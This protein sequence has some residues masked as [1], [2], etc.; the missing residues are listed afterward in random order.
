MSRAHSLRKGCGSSYFPPI[1][2]LAKW[3]MSATA[4]TS[5]WLTRFVRPR[6]AFAS[7]E[8]AFTRTPRVS[9]IPFPSPSNCRAPSNVVGTFFGTRFSVGF[10]LVGGRVALV[11]DPLPPGFTGEAFPGFIGDLTSDFEGEGGEGSGSGC[12][13]RDFLFCSCSSLSASSISAR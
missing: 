6:I 10:S 13:W 7:F 9:W 2:C 11:G 12:R 8:W 4:I 5:S 3:K 1:P